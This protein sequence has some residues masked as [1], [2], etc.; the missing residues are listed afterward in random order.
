[1]THSITNSDVSYVSFQH[2]QLF[3]RGKTSPL[4]PDQTIPSLTSNLWNQESRALESGIQLKESGILQRVYPFWDQNGLM[5]LPFGAAH[6]YVADL[7]EY[8]P[9]PRLKAT[10]NLKS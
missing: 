10:S 5:A 7:R 3:Q 1:M 8:P 4:K 6:T 2:L 9:P